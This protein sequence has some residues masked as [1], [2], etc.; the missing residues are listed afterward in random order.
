MPP[1]RKTKPTK[2]ALSTS[3]KAHQGGNGTSV[4]SK[5]KHSLQGGKTSRLAP[6]EPLHMT[7]RRAAKTASNHT[8]PAAPSIASSSSRRSSLNDL[9][10]L[11]DAS[12]PVEDVR[13]AK[14]IR[15]S[16]DSGSPQMS[17]GSFAEQ[18][19]ATES[20][21]PEPQGASS[22]VTL[23]ASKTTGK[24]R[25]ASG[26]S[27]QS[28]KT[29]SV[30][31]NGVLTRTQSDV[32]EQ[33][34]RKKRK[35]ETP[36]DPAEQPPELTD[37]STAPNSPDQIPE[38]ESSQGLQNVLPT[39]GDAPAKHARRLPGRRRQPHSDINVETDLRRQ[40]NLKMSYRSLAKIQKNLLEE[41]SKR[42]TY[43]LVNEPQ[44]Y[45]QCP[46]YEP[47]MASLDEYRQRRLNQ[48]NAERDQRL[49]QEERVLVA[50]RRIEKEQY[51]NRFRDLQDDFLL[52][53]YYRMKQ[54]ERQIK[55]DDGA[56]TDDEDNIIAPTYW[57][58]PAETGDDR[59]EPKFASRSRAYV[60]A[61]RLL[62]EEATRKIFDQQ[63][64]AFVKANEDADDA[65]ET[66]PGGFARYIGPD[67][68]EA[69]AHFNITS[70]VDA[71]FEVERTPPPEPPQVISNE[72]ADALFLLATLSE[73]RPR[74]SLV[75]EKLHDN[76]YQQ[77]API[78][79]PVATPAPEVE[80]KRQ[81]SP[82]EN[83][84]S[85][86]TT[87]VQ[88]T[89]KSSPGKVAQLLNHP[90]KPL[91][92]PEPNGVRYVRDAEPPKTE[93]PAKLSTNRITDLLNNDTDDVPSYGSR[94]IR[95]RPQEP[96]MPN[97]YRQEPVLQAHSHIPSGPLRLESIVNSQDLTTNHLP[98]IGQ[99][100][101]PPSPYWSKPREPPSE[102]A[103][104]RRDPLD[105][106]RAI[107]DRKSA[108]RTDGPP[109]SDQTESDRP[110]TTTPRLSGAFSPTDRPEAAG[111][112]SP[113]MPVQGYNASPSNPPQS[114]NESPHI[115]HA[116]PPPT[117]QPTTHDQG[118]S[119]WDG[120]RRSSGS[121]AAQAAAYNGSPAQPYSSD[122]KSAPTPPT[123]QSP[124][125]PPGGPQLPSLSQSLPPKPP[126]P[127]PSSTINFRFAHYDPAPSRP[128]Y[129]SPGGYPPVSSH[130]P[131]PPPQYP[132]SYNSQSTYQGYVPPPGSFQAPPPP[133]S[134]YP[135]LK[136][137]QY[138]G[139][140]IL[141]ANMAPP[142]HSQPQMS[143]SG[144]SASS[145]SFS[146]P[147]LPPPPSHAP[148][149]EHPSQSPREGLAERP[150]PQPRP[151]RQ[152]RSYHA[153]GTQFRT[154]QGPDSNRRRGG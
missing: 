27:S 6:S 148:Q 60:E 24:K 137:H 51:I 153:P 42:T 65:I 90:V 79:A 66:I 88:E 107:L 72:Q 86:P 82:S 127:P 120:E 45:R 33:P 29:V 77:D 152:Y 44:F 104:R 119:H 75:E 85:N 122:I 1:K 118:P 126:G 71:A 114:Y 21:T 150:E 112:E 99:H 139:Q 34:R 101:T 37:A 84:Y 97:P 46:E 143:Y 39:N 117:S 110:Q 53:C 105:R 28:S 102:E 70:L 4:M 9:A 113:R 154:Y 52:Q 135:P 115:A 129:P 54:L 138:G 10:Q 49:A 47:L 5:R 7:T 35:T 89:I 14:R 132:A 63:R 69:I 32:S 125:A 116:Y 16:T 136:I 11:D 31:P 91:T 94:D 131:P 59:L 109:R 108:P 15:L 83:F 40:L 3:P 130:G 111:K 81:A 62:D 78:P 151:R 124:Y 48:V 123:H 103:L 58:M 134:S 96:V 56:A 19:P 147:G 8:S 149:Y 93:P 36:A 26:D 141:P 74:G 61:E 145:P 68:T 18:L 57:D 23:N 92:Y 146:Q 95:S 55:A 41:L 17:N 133:P 25:R 30:R 87:A 38:V 100:Q 128:T 144:P 20:Q 12:Y 140:P 121:Q 13:P 76:Q 98:P 142:P 67:R 2:T 106:L 22:R 43:N 73:E 80:I 64:K 50:N